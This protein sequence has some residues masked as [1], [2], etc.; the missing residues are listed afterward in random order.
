MLESQDAGRRGRA[1]LGK[2]WQSPPGK[3]LYCS[4]IVYPSL[5]VEDFS[6]ITLASGLAVATILEDVTQQKMLLKWPNYVFLARK[7]CCGILTES[8]S[9]SEDEENRFAIIGVGVNVNS[10]Q[11]DFQE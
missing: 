6:K 7:K 5:S 4:L 2:H 10:E 3:G 8:S 11:K 9:L 1:R